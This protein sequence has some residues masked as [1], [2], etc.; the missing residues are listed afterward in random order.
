MKLF[1]Q[2]TSTWSV[3]E[4][5]LQTKSNGY[6]V[7]MYSLFMNVSVIFRANCFCWIC[8]VQYVLDTVCFSSNNVKVTHPDYSMLFD[9]W[10]HTKKFYYFEI[11]FFT[12]IGTLPYLILAS[13][14][15]FQIVQ[16][17]P[18]LCTQCEGNFYG[19]VLPT[20]VIHCIP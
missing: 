20:I 13:L 11:V 4:N 17:S 14:T 3:H 9:S 19:I 6:V 18:I 5:S 15:V 2:I 10:H 12:P 8:D 1:Q 16:F 7:F